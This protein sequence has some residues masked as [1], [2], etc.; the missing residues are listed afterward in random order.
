M[1]ITTSTPVG[2]IGLGIM[3][4]AMAKNLLK[5]G[6]KVAV[7]NRSRGKVDDLVKAGAIDGTSPAGVARAAEVILVCVPD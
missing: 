6:F 4:A 2:F 7:H 1:T 3:G 5:A